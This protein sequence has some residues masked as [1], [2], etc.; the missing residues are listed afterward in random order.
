MQPSDLVERFEELRREEQLDETAA[1][2]LQAPTFERLRRRAANEA[3]FARI[4]QSTVGNRK[5]D[6][7]PE[8]ARRGLDL[9]E[10]V[11][12]KAN[13]ALHEIVSNI[14]RHGYG[15]SGDHRIRVRIGQPWGNLVAL[16]SDNGAYDE[17][18]KLH[19]E[20]VA[21]LET[22][23]GT[24]ERHRPAPLMYSSCSR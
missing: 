10:D 7:S 16:L 12:F 2:M 13:L 9:L 19:R 22:A 11:L 24:R 23:L 1:E 5:T 20:S 6:R 15:A 17:A 3:Q 8:A 14:I 21:I 18:A 4:N